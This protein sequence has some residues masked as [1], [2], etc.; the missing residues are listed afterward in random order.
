MNTFSKILALEIRYQE[1]KLAEAQEKLALAP[2]GSLSVRDRKTKTDYYHNVED[3]KSKIRKRKQVNISNNQKLIL[4]LTDK[5]IQQK[6]LYRSKKN[7][8]YLKKLQANLLPI[9]TDALLPLLGTAYQQ[10]PSVSQ[11]LQT[12]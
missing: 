8:F 6:V 1:K 10:V 2:V 7:L 11:T 5:L 3:K 9:S 4:Q 12:K